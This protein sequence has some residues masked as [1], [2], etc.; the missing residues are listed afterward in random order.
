ML[1]GIP[2]GEIYK[3]LTSLM[4]AKFFEGNFKIFND[5]GVNI[6]EE[7]TFEDIVSL[8]NT[9]VNSVT[10]DNYP[11]TSEALVQNLVQAYL[12]GAGFDVRTEVHEA[13]GR[14]DLVVEL[15][16]RRIVF[17]FKYAE[18]ETEAKAKLA[19]AVEQIKSRDYGNI[20]PKKDELLRIAAVFNAD[21]KVRAFTEYESV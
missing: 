6:L 16:Y 19:E 1:L 10:Y 20:L 13:K 11:I 3:A 4:A 2:N 12:R 8:L 7:G 5:K 18:N 15:T 17:E 14:A 9:I 21:P